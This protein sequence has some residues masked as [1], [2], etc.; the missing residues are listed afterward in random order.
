LKVVYGEVNS[1]FVEVN[2]AKELTRCPW[3]RGRA[4]GQF[5]AGGKD[6]GCK[7]GGETIPA[8]VGNG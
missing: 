3:G 1:L 6:F 5:G 4:Q 7:T 8:N 2:A